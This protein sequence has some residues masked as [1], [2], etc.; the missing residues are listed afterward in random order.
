MLATREGQIPE[1]LFYITDGLCE[2]YHEPKERKLVA[3]ADFADA[4]DDDDDEDDDE[5]ADSV[6]VSGCLAMEEEYQRVLRAGAST[7]GS[8]HGSVAGSLYGPRS[9]RA[10]PGGGYG[11]DGGMRGDASVLG[12]VPA[13]SSE[14]RLLHRTQSSLRRASSVDPGKCSSR[15]GYG[16]GGGSGGAM[17]AARG[18]GINLHLQ[19]IQTSRR[20]SQGPTLSP[21]VTP[22][23][24]ANGVLHESPVG[25]ADLDLNAICDS[26]VRAADAREASFAQLEA[27]EGGGSSNGH[28]ADAT[29]GNMNGHADQGA[30]S[31]SSRAAAGGG[32]GRSGQ[33]VRECGSS[34]QVPGDSSPGD[35][36]PP[37]KN[38][39]MSGR[40]HL[41]PG[42]QVGLAK[43]AAG[44][45]LGKSFPVISCLPQHALVSAKYASY[46]L[47]VWAC[48]AQ[49][50][51]DR[52]LVFK[53]DLIT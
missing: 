9:F 47:L 52:S 41:V 2:L 45:G 4:L 28:V 20:A 16:G 14:V 32:G 49:C 12:D 39:S 51:Q 29:P 53:A 34:S 6:H 48:I 44:S 37:R 25:G 33:N 7:Q 30:G 27:F 10:S 43:W 1:G 15:G 40:E 18:E 19:A 5:D 42:S 23:H 21:P 26:V 17:G 24:R 36:A 50:Q 35:Q 3:D 13:R 46:P 38:V 8:V 11:G 22:P 31:S